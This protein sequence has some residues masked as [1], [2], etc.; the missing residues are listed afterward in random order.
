VVCEDTVTLSN[1]G[2]YRFGNRHIED[3]KENFCLFKSLHG[4]CNSTTSNCEC[5]SD[6]WR[7]GGFESRLRGPHTNK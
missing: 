6:E 7:D 3:I 4:H 5:W 2:V 1:F